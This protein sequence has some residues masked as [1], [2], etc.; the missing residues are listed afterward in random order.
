MQPSLMLFCRYFGK[1]ILFA[2]KIDVELMVFG[3]K[4]LWLV[5]H[6]FTFYGCSCLLTCHGCS[7]LLTCH[8]CSC[9]F[10]CHGGSCFLHVMAGSCLLT[11][12]GGSYLLT[13]HGGLCVLNHGGSFGSCIVFSISR[14]YGYLFGNFGS[15]C[16]CKFGNL[17][18]SWPQ[19]ICELAGNHVF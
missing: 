10:T 8:G 7:C 4:T 9:L 3:L 14:K 12:H 15:S 2:F 13:C 5:A 18:W 6:V 16:L 19:Y 1:N 17:I 11:C